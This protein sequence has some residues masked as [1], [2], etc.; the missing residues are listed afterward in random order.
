MYIFTPSW[1]IVS[2]ACYRGHINSTFYVKTALSPD[3]R[4]LLSGSSDG[5]AYIWPVDLPMT[6]PL[7]LKGHVGE[8]SGVAW[9]PADFTK[10]VTLGDDNSMNFWRLSRRSRLLPKLLDLIGWTEKTHSELGETRILV[11]LDHIIPIYDVVEWLV[12][13]ILLKFLC[14]LS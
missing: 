1:W 3:D 11:C 13:F 9:C 12:K 7:A 5:N 2:V 10:I 14:L 8:V 6:S 4:Y